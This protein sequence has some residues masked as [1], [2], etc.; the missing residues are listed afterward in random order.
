[1]YYQKYIGG[2]PKF[3]H[4]SKSIICRPTR[5]NRQ[6]QNFVD[7]PITASKF[8][9]LP[10]VHQHKRHIQAIS[11]KHTKIKPTQYY[12]D[13]SDTCRTP[14]NTKVVFAYRSRINFEDRGKPPFIINNTCSPA[15]SAT[16][17]GDPAP[18]PP[19]YFICFPLPREVGRWL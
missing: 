19:Y 7:G 17:D 10:A 4:P 1:M 2:P 11:L 15:N 16:L 13:T 6:I 9:I 3:P 5:N 12:H 14:R 8:T 18:T